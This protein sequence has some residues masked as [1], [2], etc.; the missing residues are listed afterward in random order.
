[1]PAQESTA[2]QALTVTL[3]HEPTNVETLE[4][5]TVFRHEE[6]INSKPVKS[7]TVALL[8]TGTHELFGPARSHETVG[9]LTY[10]RPIKRFVTAT[11]TY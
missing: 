10:C 4:P 3:R 2:R 1:M 11:A 7:S 9:D 6:S 5:S 8:G